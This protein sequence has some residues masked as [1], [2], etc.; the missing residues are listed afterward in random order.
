LAAC[1]PMLDMNALATSSPRRKTEDEMTAPADDHTGPN[2]RLAFRRQKGA[3]DGRPGLLWLGGFRSDM[4][5]T[6]A[7]FL[8]QWAAANGR[9]FLR[10][11]YSGH[12]E[13]DGAFEEGCIGDWAADAHSVLA[14]LTDGPQILVGSSMGGWIATLLARALP[15][16]IAA[17]V[18]IAPAPDF[19]EKLMW[20]SFTQ[21]QRDQILREGKIELPSDYSDEPEIITRRLI[22][23]GRRHL[24]MTGPIAICRPIRILQGMKDDA[25]PY[26][27]ALAFADLLDS[28]DVEVTLT[29]QGDHRLSTPADLARLAAI[30]ERL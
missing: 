22:E 15:E 9:A 23:D 17:I 14:H 1:K 11:D 7:E 12:G 20:P 16:K 30:L 18:Y 26:A 10:F 3:G 19:T 25:V 27:H 28:E 21:A 4:L 24:V 2:G 29:P 5:G 6:K 8:G 13:S